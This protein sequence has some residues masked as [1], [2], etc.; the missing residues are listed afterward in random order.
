MSKIYQIFLTCGLVV[1]AAP[2]FAEQ[3]YARLQQQV[4][5]NDVIL[6]MNRTGFVGDFF[7]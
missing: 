6:K 7:I 1:M 2:A 4:L 3:D 5:A